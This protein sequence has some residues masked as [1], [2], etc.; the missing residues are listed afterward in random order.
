MPLELTIA[1]SMSRGKL[2]ARSDDPRGVMSEVADVHEPT[3]D[4]GVGAHQAFLHQHEMWV[5]VGNMWVKRCGPLYLS[6]FSLRARV[7]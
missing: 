5:A 1:K 4:G 7:G 2:V 3:M 6:G